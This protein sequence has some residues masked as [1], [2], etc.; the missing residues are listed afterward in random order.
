MMETDRRGYNKINYNH[1][2]QKK[3]KQSRGKLTTRK[4]TQ[5]KNMLKSRHKLNNLIT[6]GPVN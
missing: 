1:K 6:V 5:S 2:Q 4:L 3:K